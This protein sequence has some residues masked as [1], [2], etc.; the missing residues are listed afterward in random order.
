MSPEKLY[1]LNT[2]KEQ[3]LSHFYFYI[4]S[5]NLVK[6]VSEKE[7]NYALTEENIMQDLFIYLEIFLR[8]NY[9]LMTR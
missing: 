4:S 2:I 3:T 8:D 1:S 7:I 5:E 9:F 6:Y